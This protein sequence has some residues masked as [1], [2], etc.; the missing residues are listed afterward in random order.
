MVFY[1]AGLHSALRGGSSIRKSS[2]SS[3][4]SVASMRES[5]CSLLGMMAE[6]DWRVGIGLVM[7]GKMEVLCDRRMMGIFQIYELLGTMLCISSKRDVGTTTWCVLKTCTETEK[8]RKRKLILLVFF[9]SVS[10]KRQS[11][12][13]RREPEDFSNHCVCIT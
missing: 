12:R 11:R 6:C 5:K 7:V 10:Q 8:P 3:R 13:L 2:V 9:L 4:S 1:T